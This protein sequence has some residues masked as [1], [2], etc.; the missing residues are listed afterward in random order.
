MELTAGQLQLRGRS[1]PVAPPL[2]LTART[3]Q[4]VLVGIGSAVARTATGLTLT[5]Q[6]RGWTGRLTVDGVPVTSRRG[7][8]ALRA[9]SALV[10]PADPA[11]PVGGLPVAAVVSEQLAAAG[12]HAPGGTAGWLTAAGLAARS[13]DRLDEVP[14]G[15]RTRL[16]IELAVHRPGVELV[17]LDSP[18]RHD[19]S[20]DWVDGCETA[21]AGTIAVVVLCAVPTAAALRGTEQRRSA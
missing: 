6:L 5:G 21:A 15:V 20:T 1:G 14:A 4:V 10:D 19:G 9:R 2:D 8:A 17:V 13:R 16:L 12:A 18:D 3:G 7:R 11:D